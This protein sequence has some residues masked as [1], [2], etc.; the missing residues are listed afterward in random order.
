MGITKMVIDKIS[1]ETYLLKNNMKLTNQ[2]S[3]IFDIFKKTKGH[4]TAEEFYIKVHLQE[5]KIGIATVYRMLKLLTEAGIADT[6]VFDDTIIKYEVK[7]DQDHHDHL[8]CEKCGKN[9][10][11]LNEEI[12]ELQ[13][14]LAQSYGFKLIRH[15]MNL[16]GLCQECNSK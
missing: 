12:E 13:E 16:Y 11:V 9:V 3:L 4:I 2:R 10:E 5:P 15:K 7:R 1:F 8:I 6:I 14:K